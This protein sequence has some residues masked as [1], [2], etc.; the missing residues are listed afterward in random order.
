MEKVNF[1]LIAKNP[2]KTRMARF[3]NQLA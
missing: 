1:H 2:G 3:Q